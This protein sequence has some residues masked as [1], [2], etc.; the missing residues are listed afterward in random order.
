[1]HRMAF[2]LFVTAGALF[3]QVERGEHLYESACAR[4][5]GTDGGGG[6]APA[7]AVPALRRGANDAEL[8]R[9]ISQGIRGTEMPPSPQL[10]NPEIEEVAAFVRSLGRVA[11]QPIPGDPLRGARIFSGKGKCLSC[12][13][14]NGQGGI[15]G[16]ELDSIGSRR[17]IAHLRQSLF[18]PDADLTDGFLQVRLRTKGGQSVT[19]LRVNENSFSVQV[20][21][22]TGRHHSFWKEELSDLRKDFNK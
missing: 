3:A 5:H 17:S 16:P 14:L 8:V 11:V 21:D 19:G 7:L 6:D 13:S 18:N 4:C 15:I 9:I 20:L 10:T 2:V 1:M 22:Y 12:H